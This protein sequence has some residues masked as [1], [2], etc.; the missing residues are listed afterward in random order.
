LPSTTGVTLGGTPV[1]M[2]ERVL[3]VGGT[4]ENRISTSCR[5]IQM[6]GFGTITARS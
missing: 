6:R 1:Q 5:E 4:S 3:C 2:K